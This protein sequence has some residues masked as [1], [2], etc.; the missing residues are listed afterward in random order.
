[1]KK[2][3]ETIKEKTNE[4]IENKRKQNKDTPFK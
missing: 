4:R 3:H 1:M 2:K